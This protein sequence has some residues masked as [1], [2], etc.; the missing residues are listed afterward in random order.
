MS[1]IFIPMFYQQSVLN[2]KYTIFN[3]PIVPKF[4]F[5]IVLSLVLSL[6]KYMYHHTISI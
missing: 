5:G 1:N 2:N 6:K 4:N 3:K